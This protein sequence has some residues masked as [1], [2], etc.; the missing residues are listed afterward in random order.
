MAL[1]ACGLLAAPAAAAGAAPGELPALAEQGSRPAQPATLPPAEPAGEGPSARI[2]GGGTTT[3]GNHPWQAALVLDPAKAPGTTDLQ[4]LF[5]GGTLITP[6][7]VLTAAHCVFDTDPDCLGAGGCVDPTGDGTSRLDP[8]DVDVVVG[9]TTMTGAGGTE[10]DA[11]RT[12]YVP[13]GYNPATKEYDFAY[14][15]LLTPSTQARIDIVDRNDLPA[16]KVGAPTRV[17]GYGYTAAGNSA[18][19]SDTLKVATVPIISDSSCAKPAVYG[20]IFFRL[21]QI[22]AGFLGGGTD[23]CQGDS[24]GPLQTA[25]G[26]ASG[27]TRLVGV[28]S[29]GV[30]CAVAN[31]PGVYT[32]VAQN[33]LCSNQVS[34]VAQIEDVETIPAALRE[35]VVGPAGCS[36]EQFAAKK[37]C[38]RK[39]KGKRRGA[40]LA[41]KKKCKRKRKGR[42]R[43]S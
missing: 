7:I 17:S 24:G 42:K 41:K 10:H 2:I 27:A 31:S 19:K 32:R 35:P 26:A 16:W 40:A 38:K 6:Y 33:P 25:A 20:G 14:V 18:S 30:G 21:V 5:C 3:A 4:R 29:F 8:N 11:F 9:R 1:L 28:V 15:S 23:S 43:G 12:D 13:V 36:S 34:N 22:C 39:K 37:K